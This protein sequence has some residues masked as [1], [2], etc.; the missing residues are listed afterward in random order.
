MKKNTYASNALFLLLIVFLLPGCS[1][2]AGI[3]KA[4][5]WTGILIVGCI[6][7]LVIF[8]LSRGSKK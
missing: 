8:L 5:V 6:L 4:G 7:F 1:A 2:I 3:F